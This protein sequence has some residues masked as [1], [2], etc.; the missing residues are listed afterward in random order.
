MDKRIL[1]LEVENFRSLRKISLPLRPLNV[2]VGPNGAGKTNVLEVFRFLADVIRTDLQP[3]LDLRGGFDDVVF[4]GG[5]KPPA[6]IKIKLKATWTTHSSVSA[7]D[8]YELRVTRR[9]QKAGAD[10]LS[11]KET[12][13]FKRTRGRGRRITITGQKI[14]VFGAGPDAERQIG[15]QKMSS[16]L[17][18][19]PRLADEEGGGE[20]ATV[21]ERLESFRVF[22][23]DVSAARLPAKFPHREAFL[24]EDARNLSSFLL[25]L[26]SR[27]EEAWQNLVEDAIR[28]LPHLEDIAFEYPSGAA[29]EVIVVLREHGLRQP[30]QLADASYGTIRLLGLLALL[31]D[32]EP[33]ALTC[34]EEID[35]GLHPQALELLVERLRDASE[36]TQFLIAT[37]SP[38]LVDRLRPEEIVIC[39]RLDDGSSAIPALSTAEI[40]KIVTKSEGLPLGELWFSGTL[41]GGL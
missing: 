19:L 15:I 1:E 17:S 2:L 40:E 27:D 28:V 5:D 20:V 39:E 25:T 33:P 36:R 22:D 32:P 29:R 4:R 14:S 41:G 26:R 16:G 11:R 12:F 8:E 35:H 3:A 38:A 13:Q 7:P 31:Y 24:Y 18:T 30:T 23:V 10:S 6:S 34:V 37:H 9:T 21:A